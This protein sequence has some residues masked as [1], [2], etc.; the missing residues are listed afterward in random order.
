MNNFLSVLFAL[1]LI[2]VFG[3][4]TQTEDVT[5]FDKYYNPES[6]FIDKVIKKATIAKIA[7]LDSSQQVLDSTYYHRK[8]IAVKD[9][10]KLETERIS[11]LLHGLKLFK[12]KKY[13]EAFKAL[14]YYCAIYFDPHPDLCTASYYK[15]KSSLNTKGELSKNIIYDFEDFLDLP[16]SNTKM[17]QQ[18]NYE[19]ILTMIKMDNP[20]AKGLLEGT[21]GVRNHHREKEIKEIYDLLD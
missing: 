18:G 21:F 15:A 12:S 16:G 1:T 3:C 14:E 9:Y 17:Y 20:N 8:R 11:Y 6:E 4:K 10:E 5:L 7:P 13:S 2:F 19:M